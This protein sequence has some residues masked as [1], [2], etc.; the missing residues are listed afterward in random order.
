MSQGDLRGFTGLRLRTA[1]PSVAEVSPHES[2]DDEGEQEADH[3]RD[4]GID[5]LGPSKEVA[6]F[7]SFEVEVHLL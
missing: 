2:D 1:R 7:P 5:P 3:S 6:G 4:G